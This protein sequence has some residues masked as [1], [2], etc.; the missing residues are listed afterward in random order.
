MAFSNVTGGGT[1]Y[2]MAAQ[3]AAM[4]QMQATDQQQAATIQTQIAADAA[5]QQMERFKLM[6]DLQTKI[7]EMTQEI[8]LT[9][10]KAAQ[11]GFQGVNAYISS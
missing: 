4:Q 11:K 10:Q 5:K 8:T 3:N 7:M 2:T 9:K 1:Q 6:A